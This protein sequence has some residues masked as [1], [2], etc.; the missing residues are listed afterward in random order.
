MAA[1]SFAELVALLTVAET[2]RIRKEDGEKVL[3]RLLSGL[4]SI[5]GLHASMPLYV[6]ESEKVGVLARKCCIGICVEDE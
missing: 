1:F 6:V 2:A 3:C 5:G 4:I